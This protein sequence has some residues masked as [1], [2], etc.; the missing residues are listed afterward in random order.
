MKD[1]ILIFAELQSILKDK[2]YMTLS[3]TEPAGW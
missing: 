3:S 2:L 1:S